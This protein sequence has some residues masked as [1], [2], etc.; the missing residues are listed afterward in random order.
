MRTVT[1]RLAKKLVNL[2][3]SEI[4]N[5][6]MKKTGVDLEEQ[7]RQMRTEM[8][9]I[10][11]YFLSDDVKAWQAQYEQY[12][13]NNPNKSQ[14][15]AEFSEDAMLQV[16]DPDWPQH[17]NNVFRARE[18]EYGRSMTIMLITVDKLYVQM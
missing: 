10:R 3:E 6:M 18:E 13:Q 7:K 14:S 2:D 15:D 17:T 9:N 12:R 4:G 11:Q 1:K 16:E 5:R 8:D